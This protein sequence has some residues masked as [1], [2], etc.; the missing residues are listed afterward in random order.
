MQTTLQINPNHTA[1]IAGLLY[2]LL[3]PLGIIG[4]IYVPTNIIV[5]N[6]LAATASNLLNNELMVRVSI[7]SALVVQ[8]VNLA[9]VIALYKLLSPAHV[10]AAKL[11]ML[12]VFVAVPIAM[13]NEVL[14]YAALE[15]LMNGELL[16]AFSQAQ[17]EALSYML[18]QWHEFGVLIASIFW[19][20]WLFPMGYLVY[21]S[22]FLPK[23][24]GVLLMIGCFGYLADAYIGLMLPHLDIEI[25]QFT[26]IGEVAL[27]LWLIIKGVNKEVWLQ[28]NSEVIQA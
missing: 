19:G 8:I 11:M 2:L 4:I 28:K 21:K 14:N 5:L 18:L 7:T 25:A 20:F 6:D 13:L 27:P 23:T 22:N 9:V 24:I 3:V 15:L 17:L 12:F 1:R 16:S 26:F 10:F